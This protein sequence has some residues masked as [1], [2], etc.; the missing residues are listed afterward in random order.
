MTTAAPPIPTSPSVQL[1]DRDRERYRL[2]EQAGQGAHSTVF[3]AVDASSGRTVAVRLPRADIP[4]EDAARVH[5][6]EL[7]AGKHEGWRSPAVAQVLDEVTTSEGRNALV[8]EWIDGKTL[9]GYLKERGVMSLSSLLLLFGPLANALDKAHRAGLRHGDLKPSNLMIWA[10]DAPRTVLI[11][12]GLAQDANADATMTTAVRGTPRYLAPEIINGKLADHRADLYAFACIL[13][14]CL[15]GQAPFTQQDT[16]ALLYAHTHTPATPPSEVLPTLPS[17][18]DAVFATALAKAPE[19]RFQ[20]ATALLD[21]LFVATAQSSQHIGKPKPSKWR[22]VWLAVPAVLVMGFAAWLIGSNL[23]RSQSAIA[24]AATPTLAPSTQPK[25]TEPAPTPTPDEST[26]Q[27]INNSTHNLLFTPAT[28]SGNTPLLVGDALYISDGQ[29]RIS[30]VDANS[31]DAWWQ[32]ALDPPL[33]FAVHIFGESGESLIAANSSG[34]VQSWSTWRGVPNWT[35]ATDFAN[36]SFSLGER[37]VVARW[38]DVWAID[39][40]E[41]RVTTIY[42]RSN[43]AGWATDF[44]AFGDHALV[45]SWNGTIQE[46]KLGASGFEVITR[47]TNLDSS[48]LTAPPTEGEG[49]IAITYKRGVIRVWGSDGSEKWT[50]DLG[51]AMSAPPLIVRASES[52][53][54]LIVGAEDG[55]VRAF[56]VETQEQAWEYK[57]GAAVQV[58]PALWPDQ[59]VIVGA[60]NGE[61]VLLDLG[62]G[63][64]KQTWAVQGSVRTPVVVDAANNRAFVRANGIWVLGRVQ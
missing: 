19:T 49:L 48:N 8:T 30:R 54:L 21:A 36:Q 11:D 59:G 12:F 13:Y 27:P 58:E 63:A 53:V 31:G 43:D 42:T 62:S 55:T 14:E 61:V 20:S 33:N 35:L 4:A 2:I 23:N 40:Y 17:A 15:A 44:R 56:D 26:P 18:V 10:G 52:Q 38:E 51:E 57:F 29:G 32:V 16:P 3:R 5:R 1:S 39:P 7:A 47:V 37:L 6:H 60:S 45:A 25:P 41:G 9:S 24:T 34:Q 28:A 64:A 22:W 46:F 50:R